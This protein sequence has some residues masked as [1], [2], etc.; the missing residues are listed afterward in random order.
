MDNLMGNKEWY[1]GLDTEVIGE[2]VNKYQSDEGYVDLD[3]DVDDEE[4]LDDEVELVQ[5]LKE[6]H[7]IN[8]KKAKHIKRK[9]LREL[10]NKG[11]E[12]YEDNPDKYFY[13]KTKKTKAIRQHEKELRNTR[14][15]RKELKLKQII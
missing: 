6:K 5:S 11:V 10:K 7:A 8:H 15:R 1:E 9:K 4:L 12:G 2:L 13:K 14:E 3:T